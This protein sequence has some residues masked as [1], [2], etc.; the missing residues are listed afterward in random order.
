MVQM[1]MADE[2][3]LDLLGQHVADA[4]KR[5]IRG[6]SDR[7]EHAFLV[8]DAQ[9]VHQRAGIAGHGAAVA[10]RRD[11]EGAEVAVLDAAARAERH[12]VEAGTGLGE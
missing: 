7:I 5:R 3:T 8:G 6:H 1:G 9:A 10:G 12:H 2:V 11:H 4:R